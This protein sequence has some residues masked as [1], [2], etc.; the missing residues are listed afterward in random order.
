[1]THAVRR[2]PLQ[3]RDD[4]APADVPDLR[5][6]AAGRRRSA[7]SWAARPTAGC[8]P[9]GRTQHLKRRPRAARRGRAAAGRDPKAIEIAPFMAIIPFDDAAMARSMIKPLVSLL[10]RRHGH[11]LPRALLPLRLGGERRTW[12]ATSTTPGKRKEAAAAVADDL[13]DAIAICGPPDALPRASSRS[14][15]TAGVGTA[16]MNRTTT[17][18]AV[19]GWPS[20]PAPARWRCP[21]GSR[22][23]PS[24]PAAAIARTATTGSAPARSSRADS[25]ALAFARPLPC[26]LRT[27]QANRRDARHSGSGGRG[28][29]AKRILP[30]RTITAHRGSE[31]SSALRGCET[32]VAAEDWLRRRP[33]ATGERHPGH[34]RLRPPRC[35]DAGSVAETPRRRFAKQRPGDAHAPVITA[36]AARDDDVRAGHAP[37]KLGCRTTT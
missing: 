10:H 37:P 34:R 7:R 28:D 8:R 32:A 6:V 1:M 3:A 14:G 30:S 23:W 25:D 9:S 22:R 5:R 31:R 19:Q 11:L 27:P 20:L 4:A 21:G 33:G 17:R 15:A 24:A 12:C 13:V 36:F 26:L 2:A 18:R 16:L 35:R 29:A